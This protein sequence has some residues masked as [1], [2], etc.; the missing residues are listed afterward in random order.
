VITGREGNLYEA[1]YLIFNIYLTS[2]KKPRIAA[3][4][5][6]REPG[7]AGDTSRGYAIFL[8]SF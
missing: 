2:I 4:P 1:D 6:Y 3:G 5:G 8:I 7:R